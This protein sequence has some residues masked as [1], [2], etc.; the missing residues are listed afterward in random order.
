MRKYSIRLATKLQVASNLADDICY[1][2]DVV[3]CD[4]RHSRLGPLRQ[5]DDL[6]QGAQVVTGDARVVTEHVVVGYGKLSKR[7]RKMVAVVKQGL[8]AE[9]SDDP[10]CVFIWYSNWL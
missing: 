9:P 5:C 1:L 7:R 8:H 4:V 10:V 2:V 6:P 3:D